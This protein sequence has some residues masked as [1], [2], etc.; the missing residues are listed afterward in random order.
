MSSWALD[1]QS[2][3][4]ESLNIRTAA[5]APTTLICGFSNAGVGELL[6]V[7]VAV[8]AAVGVGV[9]VVVTVGVGVI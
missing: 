5:S 3:L 7:G 6:G 4:P 8:A 2:N 9:N 1:S